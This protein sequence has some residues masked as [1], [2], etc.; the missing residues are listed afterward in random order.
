MTHLGGT[1]ADYEF[2][3]FRDRLADALAVRHSGGWCAECGRWIEDAHEGDRC[4]CGGIVEEAEMAETQ[5]RTTTRPVAT[6]REDG[7]G[8]AYVEVDDRQ[9]PLRSAW[10]AEERVTILVERGYAIADPDHVLDM[11]GVLTESA[12]SV[13]ELDAD[14]AGY[15]DT[16]LPAVGTPMGDALMSEIE[17]MRSFEREEL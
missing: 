7:H 10:Q 16:P 3:R 15:P 8:R 1:R 9:F 11:W 17:F 6:V 5:T 12:S 14:S 13:R 2:D 4:E